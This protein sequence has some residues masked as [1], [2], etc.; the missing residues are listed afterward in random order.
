MDAG[1]NLQL[2]PDKYGTD[3]KSAPACVH[4][5]IPPLKGARGMFKKNAR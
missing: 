4:S 5:L 2:V 1:A 3:Y